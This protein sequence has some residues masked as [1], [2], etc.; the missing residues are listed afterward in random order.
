MF[1]KRHYEYLARALRRAAAQA[2]SAEKRA[3][4]RYT[5]FYLADELSKDNPA[6]SRVKF[7]IACGLED[8]E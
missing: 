4:I 5:A 7:L 1:S 6:F 8:A 3:V 2:Q